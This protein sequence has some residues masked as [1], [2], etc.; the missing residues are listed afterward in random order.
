M[1]MDEDITS[2]SR[3]AAADR[4]PILS[5]IEIDNLLSMRLIP[6]LATLNQDGG[7][8][9]LPMWFLRVGNDIDLPTSSHTHKYW[10]VR[11]RPRASVMIDVSRVGFDLKGVLIRGLVELVYGEDVRQINRLIH[12]KYVT[13]EG[14][15]E[16]NV[17]AYLSKGD[18]VTVKI[19]MDHLISWNLVGSKAGGK[20]LSLRQIPST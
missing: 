8:H 18:D 15:S 10:N 14:L 5:S 7:V 12:L 16:A 1:L 4:P 20:A 9:L 13:P 3:D 19:Y 17:A 6:N 11:E 2:R